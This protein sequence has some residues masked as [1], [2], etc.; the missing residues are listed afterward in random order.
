MWYL[1]TFEDL[2]FVNLRVSQN[3]TNQEFESFEDDKPVF[4]I[5]EGLK[6]FE[7]DADDS[8]GL[9]SDYLSELHSL[10]KGQFILLNHA[11]VLLKWV[12]DIESLKQSVA[13]LLGRKDKFS[14]FS[15]TQLV[16]SNFLS[17]EGI[18]GLLK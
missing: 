1:I 17:L 11:A 7:I 3:N 10:S 18:N 16:A 15:V 14:I 2:Q 6:K 5:R 12:S 4:N 9:T 13:E 8:G